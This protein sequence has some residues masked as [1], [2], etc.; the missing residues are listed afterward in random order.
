MEQKS[1]DT[2]KVHAGLMLVTT[3]GVLFV[4]NSIVLYLANLFFPQQIVL[5][6][7]SMNPIWSIA[8]SM[9]VLA[10]IGMLALPFFHLAEQ[11]M[12]R[13]LSTIEWMIGYYLL[14]V[15]AVWILARFSDQFGMGISG[16]YVAVALA[17]VFTLVQG[18]AMMQIQKMT[19]QS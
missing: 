16:W 8:H 12:G 7:M 11:K 3:Y 14:N 9:G 6:T 4:V 15:V 5:G 19:P 2:I 13:M 10:L 17:I 18:L 1:I